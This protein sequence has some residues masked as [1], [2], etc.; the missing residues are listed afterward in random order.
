MG[1]ERGWGD[2]AQRVSETIHLLLEILQAP[3]PSTLETFLGRIPM[4]FNVV[5]VSPHGYFSQAN[6]LGLPDTGGQIV[7]ILDQ[8]RA[9]E[10]EMLLRIQKQGLDVIPKILIVTRLIPDAKGTTCNQRLER[11]SG[12][13]HT[14]I[15]RVPFRTENGILRKWI[16][17]FDVG[18]YLETFAEL[19]VAKT[20]VFHQFVLYLF[21]ISLSL[22]V[23]LLLP[24]DN[25]SKM[26][27]KL[28]QVGFQFN[29]FFLLA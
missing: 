19:S 28:H 8:V 13:K 29:L 10:D 3:D 9:L 2:I 27:E 4:L 1:F 25:V 7:Y 18:P 21:F 15:L 14:H 20:L 6:I 24:C 26:I 5:I 22:C 12:T 17:R 16:S 23:S 11:I